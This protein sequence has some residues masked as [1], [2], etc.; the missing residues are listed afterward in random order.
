[1]THHNVR[2]ALSSGL[3]SMIAAQDAATTIAMRVPILV[4]AL[5]SP[6]AANTAEAR[7]ALDEK[8]GA[9]IDGSIAM[10]FCWQ[11]LFWDM[12][13]GRA[14]VHS[15]PGKLLAIAE[16]GARPARRRVRANAKRLTKP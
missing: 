1:M 8:V 12:A 13:F 9:A 7:R 10:A 11:R 2:A 14:G 3:S 5:V 16:S 15:L 4:S 6:T